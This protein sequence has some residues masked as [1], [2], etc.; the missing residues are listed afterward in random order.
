VTL[1]SFADATN[2]MA[3][4][5]FAHRAN[6]TSTVD[7]SPAGYA[8]LGNAGSAATNA[9]GILTERLTGQDT[10]VSASWATSIAGCGV[11]LEIKMA[12]AGAASL[13]YDPTQSIS[14]LIGR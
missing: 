11:A 8:A 6:E 1:A 3:I 5:G 13:V 10:A 2:N 14:A 7:A 12:V 4:G 9:M